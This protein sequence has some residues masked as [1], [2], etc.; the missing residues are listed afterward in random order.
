MNYTDFAKWLKVQLR[1]R[2]LT[3]ADL[4]R[5]S[6]LSP[7][8][9]SRIVKVE[10]TPSQDALASIARALRIGPDEVFRAAGLL[11]S[12]NDNLSPVK[13]QLIHLAEQADDSAVGMAIAALDAAITY[14]LDIPELLDVVQRWDRRV[15]KLSPSA[16]WYATLTHDSMAITETV[17]AFL[18]RDNAIQRDVRLICDRAGVPYLSPHKLRHGH[19]VYALKKARNMGELKAISQN[20]MHASVTITDQIY[21]GLTGEDIKNVIGGLGHSSGGDVDA[22]LAELIE[23][24]RTGSN[25]LK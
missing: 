9:V 10:S 23:L 15:R 25:V 4:A 13:R 3:Q 8:Q 12:A 1:E 5:L 19:I 20:V 24:L 6:G 18:G 16:L 7:S 22:K 21:G 11:P 14:L 17:Q 2:R